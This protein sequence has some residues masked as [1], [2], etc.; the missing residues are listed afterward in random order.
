MNYHLAFSIELQAVVGRRAKRGLSQ[1]T[2][3]PESR[4]P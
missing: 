2:G 1:L 3:K 4:E